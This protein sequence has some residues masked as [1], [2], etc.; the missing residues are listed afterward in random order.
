M[1]KEKITCCG[2]IRDHI[3]LAGMSPTTP[4]LSLLEI[5][6]LAVLLL[7]P[8]ALRLAGMLPCR[9]MAIARQQELV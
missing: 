8:P 2:P 7:L 4:L 3:D 5:T 6:P 9:M 1:C